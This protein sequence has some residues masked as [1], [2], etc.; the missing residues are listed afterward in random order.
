MFLILPKTL[1]YVNY[2]DLVKK[3]FQRFLIEINQN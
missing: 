1:I 2:E 3:L